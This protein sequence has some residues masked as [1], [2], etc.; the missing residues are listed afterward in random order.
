MHIELHKQHIFNTI[1]KNTKKSKSVKKK[2]NDNFINV[3]INNN[4]TIIKI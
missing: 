2:K 3:H 1:K 4:K